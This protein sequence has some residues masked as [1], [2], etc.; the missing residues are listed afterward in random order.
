MEIVQHWKLQPLSLSLFPQEFD[1]ALWSAISEQFNAAGRAQIPLCDL[2]NNAALQRLVYRFLPSL[3]QYLSDDDTDS[4][5]ENNYIGS[6][7]LAA[8][9]LTKIL[10]QERHVIVVPSMVQGTSGDCFW[11]FERECSKA[12]SSRSSRPIFFH[13]TFQDKTSSVSWTPIHRLHSSFL[14]FLQ[15]ALQPEKYGQLKRVEFE[16]CLSCMM[17]ENVMI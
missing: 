9:I 16:T 10:M 6:R 8:D 14:S 4:I 15:K 12:D 5:D 13:F 11:M 7:D 17:T 1:S 3:L 2:V